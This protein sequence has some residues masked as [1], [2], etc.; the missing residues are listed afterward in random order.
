MLV[1]DSKRLVDIQSLLLFKTTLLQFRYGD[2]IYYSFSNAKV[3]AFCA[4]HR[5]SE[6]CSSLKREGFQKLFMIFVLL[7]SSPNF[8]IVTINT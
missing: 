5:T 4:K 1:A 8:L 6:S 3:G 2:L 7:L